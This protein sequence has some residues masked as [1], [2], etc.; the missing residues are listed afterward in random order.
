MIINVHAGHN[1]DGRIANGA[2]GL[3]KE[4][5]QSRKIVKYMIKYLKQSGQTVYNCTCNN[6]LSQ[7]DVLEKI[8]DKCN[9]HKAKLDV[10]IHFNSGA[11]KER[12]D[13]KTTGTE[14]LVYKN[15]GKIKTVASK[16]AKQIE[17]LGFKNRGVKER[18]DLYFLNQTKAPAMLVECCFVDDEDDVELYDAKKMAKAI[19]TGILSSY[20]FIVVTTKRGVYLR[21]TAGKKVEKTGRLPKGTKCSITKVC[22]ADNIVYGYVKKYNRWISLKNTRI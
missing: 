13:G 4:S 14:V 5:T 17:Y 10:S 22:I 9:E 15:S 19:V 18:P 8:I 20:T 2:V 3:I 21:K 11:V 16:T 1:P 6:G 7:K 12:S